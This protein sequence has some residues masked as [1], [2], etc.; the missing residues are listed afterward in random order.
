MLASPENGVALLKNRPVFTWEAEEEANY[1]ISLHE[2]PERLIVDA[3]VS[4]SS[5]Q[6]PPELTLEAGKSYRW[7]V[8]Y[9]SPNDGK[10]YSAI[11]SFSVVGK[12]E[13]D[14]VAALKPAD[15]A[16]IE[17]W[18]MYAALLQNRQIREEARNAWQLI[19][20]RRPDL[21][22]AQELAR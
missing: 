10:S 15:G 18:I 21:R 8:S 17:E 4:D 13:A 3:K 14:E 6:L 9:V 7:T 19:A 12:A 2:L 20:A 11:S 22:K 16:A 5:W 1:E